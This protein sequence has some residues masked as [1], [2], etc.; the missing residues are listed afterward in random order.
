MGESSFSLS[1]ELAM[2]FRSSPQP[3]GRRKPHHMTKSSR[4]NISPSSANWPLQSQSRFCLVRYGDGWYYLS[5]PH[6]TQSSV[7]R[8]SIL[9]A[10]C[11]CDGLNEPSR[12]CPDA[13]RRS[14]NFKLFAWNIFRYTAGLDAK[15][16]F[17]GINADSIRSGCLLHC[18]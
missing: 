6:I 11:G 7:Y 4:E 15:A 18:I 10:H 5:P 12:S 2:R 13:R 9:K 16:L 14:R 17:A 1:K 8:P 3:R